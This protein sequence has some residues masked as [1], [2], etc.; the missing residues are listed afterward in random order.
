MMYPGSVFF[1][2][3]C[4]LEPYA[5]WQN[6]SG[7]RPMP[8]MSALPFWAMFFLIIAYGPSSLPGLQALHA[9]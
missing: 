7:L 2:F 6:F 5:K 8:Y 1:W 3:K 9:V 4:N